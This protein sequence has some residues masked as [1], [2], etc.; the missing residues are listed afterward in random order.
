M[1]V[2]KIESLEQFNKIL[3]NKDGNKY[4]FVDFYANWC[5]PCKR[6]APE[7]EKFSDIYKNITFLK[8]DVEEVEDLSNIYGIQSLPTFLIFEI[9]ETKPLYKPIIGSD[10]VKI[11]TTLKSLTQK[12]NSKSDF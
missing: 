8:V 3:I 10:K 2:K 5:G 1:T 4:I 6:I 9:G 7:I 11:E 12:P